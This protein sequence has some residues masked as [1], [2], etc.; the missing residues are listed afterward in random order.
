MSLGSGEILHGRAERFRRKQANVHLEIVAQAKADFVVA[1]G[2]DAHQRWIFRDVF[3]RLLAL[4]R[5]AASRAR[6]QDVEIPDGFAAAAQR[7]GRRDLVEAGKLR[8]ISGE[9]FRLGFGDIDQKPSGDSAIVFDGLQQFLLM[10]FAHARQFADLAFAGKLFHA[11]D[12]RDL[13]GVPNQRNRLRPE[14][15]DL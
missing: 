5:A 12:V 4:F 1:L 8:E 9:F 14:T 2:D 6:N 10:L 15:L 7:A 11:I 3:D 13:I